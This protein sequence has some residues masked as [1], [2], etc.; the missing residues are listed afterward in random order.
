MNG[1][2]WFFSLVL[3]SSPLPKEYRFPTTSFLL[4][5]SPP[6]ASRLMSQPSSTNG[7]SVFLHFEAVAIIALFRLKVLWAVTVDATPQHF[8]PAFGYQSMALRC[9]GI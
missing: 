1:R 7:A 4:P 8:S 9:C 5:P 3:S 6:L 2:D